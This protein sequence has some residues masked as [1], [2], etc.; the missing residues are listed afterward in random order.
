MNDN[1]KREE[2]IRAEI[3]KEDWY[4]EEAARIEARQKEIDAL[5]DKSFKL[6][7][8]I[9]FIERMIASRLKLDAVVDAAISKFTP[10]MIESFT[11]KAAEYLQQLSDDIIKEIP[12]EPLAN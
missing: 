1:G 9:S 12:H 7:T 10:E 3:M 5:K 2:E 8:E 4:V 11:L 6:R